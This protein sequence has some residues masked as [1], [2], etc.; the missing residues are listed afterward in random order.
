MLF[1]VLS[2]KILLLSI[3]RIASEKIHET[4]IKHFIMSLRY[5]RKVISRYLSFAKHKKEP[6]FH[7]QISHSYATISYQSLAFTRSTIRTRVTRD[8]FCLTIG[9]W[10]IRARS[11]EGRA[12][13][14]TDLHLNRA[15]FT[16]QWAPV[17]PGTLSISL[18]AVCS[19]RSCGHVDR[20][21]PCNERNTVFP[22][23]YPSPPPFLFVPTS[24]SP[25]A[26][27]LKRAGAGQKRRN[28][29]R[30]GRRSGF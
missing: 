24:V 21:L 6:R 22:S 19:M 27:A 9:I 3:S 29:S 2:R 17:C 26:R 12:S 23:R 4:Q 13:S 10:K 5:N 15:S 1:H 28:P 8:T 25:W 16:P 11:R 20:S 30:L 18:V 7:T 14:A